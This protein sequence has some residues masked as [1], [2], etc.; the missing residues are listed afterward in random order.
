MRIAV[1]CFIALLFFSCNKERR[2]NRHLQGTWEVDLVKLQD[3]DGFSFF[4]YY[5]TGS[6][7]ITD[8]SVQG[9][10]TAAF[11][12][13][14]GSV[15]DTLALQGTYLLKLNES[16]LNW[17]QAP[18]TIKN[19]IFAITNKNLEIEYYNAQAQQR[20]RYVFKKVN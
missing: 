6:V 7:M 20:L 16:E 19:R 4:D 18:D 5:P 11:Q 3:A 10:L 13:F 2:L 9:E 8:E 17:V 1:L 14:Q 15:A 12:T